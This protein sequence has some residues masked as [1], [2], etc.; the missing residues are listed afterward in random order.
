MASI[1]SDDIVDVCV[2]LNPTFD[3]NCM[4]YLMWNSVGA[5]FILFTARRL[6]K[7]AGWRSILPRHP[8][9]AHFFRGV[10]KS[11]YFSKAAEDECKSSAALGTDCEWSLPQL[12]H[13]GHHLPRQWQKP[14]C[15]Q[16]IYFFI[17]AFYFPA[18]AVV[19]A[20]SCLLSEGEIFVHNRQVLHSPGC[21]YAG[22]YQQTEA[23]K[24][25]Q[26]FGRNRVY[27]FSPLAKCHST[28]R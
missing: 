21:S 4:S 25:S 24:E 22:D 18:G 3:E 15:N 7:L 17:G 2:Q 6:S 8:Q 20:I 26:R 16:F 12:W 23:N 5:G 9:D 11:T 1:S 13:P 14:T 19:A 10:L 28:I 27:H